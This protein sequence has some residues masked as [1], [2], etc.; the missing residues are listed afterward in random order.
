MNWLSN[1]LWAVWAG[2][3][4]ILAVGE[5]TLFDF[6]LM[7]LAAGALAGAGVALIF[8]GL[9]WLQIVVALVVAVAMLWLVR[10]W[11]RNATHSHAEVKSGAQH[12]LGKTG[13]VVKEITAEGTGAIRI[14]GDLWTARSYTGETIAEG[15]RVEVMEIDGATAIVY[16][17]ARPL[18]EGVRLPD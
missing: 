11:L 1:H 13:P 7:M 4:V 17:A 9:L 18:D 2:L 8:P 10:P 14:G 12:M 15:E 16:P 5:V 6:T 3:A